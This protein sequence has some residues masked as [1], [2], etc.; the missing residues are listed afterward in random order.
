D[1]DPSEALDR[2]TNRALD[3][4]DARHVANEPD[5]LFAPQPLRRPTHRVAVEVHERNGRSSGDQRLRDAVSD[6]PRPAGDHRNL[7]AYVVAR[8]PMR[9]LASPPAGRPPLLRPRGS[10]SPGPRGRAP[11]AGT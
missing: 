6:P 10:A 8:H 3:R 11:T 1:V 2:R 5:R 9:P 7:A 4:L